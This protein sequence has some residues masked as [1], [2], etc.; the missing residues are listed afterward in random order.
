MVIPQCLSPFKHPLN[1]YATEAMDFFKIIWML[2]NGFWET[3]PPLPYELAEL[4]L[5]HSGRSI[6][7]FAE[8]SEAINLH[9]ADRLYL[10]L[11]SLPRLPVRYR[12][13]SIEISVESH[14][15]GWSDSAREDVG[16][17]RNS[18]TWGEMSVIVS[19]DEL[20][21]EDEV[22]TAV[23]QLLL[24]P[25]TS[26]SSSFERKLCTN[27]EGQS[28]FRHRIFTNRH[29]I[30]QWQI[31]DCHMFS[32]SLPDSLLPTPLG[33]HTLDSQDFPR[34]HIGDVI[35]TREGFVDELKPGDGI[36]VWLRSAFPGWQIFAKSAR[37]E[38]QI[39]PNF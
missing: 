37:I 13:L 17:F 33:T 23:N 32:Q 29:A 9:H 36:A 26:D 25:C 6:S 34:T 39:R 27:R 11:D 35:A 7:L 14:D 20:G 3:L 21:L 24:R 15:Q 8:T 4:I 1:S 30:Q 28:Q 16:T 22:Q 19:R 18:W 5:S 38:V 10:R 31:K 2:R 12:V